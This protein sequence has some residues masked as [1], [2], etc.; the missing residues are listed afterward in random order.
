MKKT[1]D[2][3]RLG[4]NVSELGNNAQEIKAE[5]VAFGIQEDEIDEAVQAVLEYN[6][7]DS[8]SMYSSCNY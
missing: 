8:W 2:I 7:Q 4:N 3:D 5:L 1:F 6:T